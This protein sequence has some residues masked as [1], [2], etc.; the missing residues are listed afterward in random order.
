MGWN[1][2]LLYK[3]MIP[4]EVWKKVGNFKRLLIKHE[5][6]GIW[7][8][9]LG[10]KRIITRSPVS[11]LIIKLGSLENLQSQKMGMKTLFGQ[12]KWS[13]KKR[14]FIIDK[15]VRILFVCPYILKENSMYV[16]YM[17]LSKWKSMCTM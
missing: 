8:F 12:W 1:T 13:E 11:S 10:K 17:I 3:Y 9:G 15:K 2:I 4:T 7:G 14:N 6:S 16:H 5:K